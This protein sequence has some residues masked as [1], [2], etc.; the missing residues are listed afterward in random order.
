[1]IAAMSALAAIVLTMSACSSEGARSSESTLAAVWA[2]KFTQALSDPN[3]S[4]FAT[5]VLSD[6]MITQAEYQESFNR[7]CQCLADAG[8]TV[9]GTPG[10]YSV[11]PPDTGPITNQSKAMEEQ[12][13]IIN[14]CQNPDSDSAW[15]TI[16]SI[17]EGLE[18]DPLGLTIEQ[19]IKQCY[20]EHGVPDG[21]GMSDDQFNQMVDDP[22]YVPSTPDAT[23]CLWD[24]TGA[25]GYTIEQAEQ[26][27]A[28]VKS[29]PTI[30][31]SPV[32]TDTG[33]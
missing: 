14:T 24:P 9:S 2:D 30:S 25:M 21:A 13:G 32:P 16:S 26:L 5:Q 28:N 31:S 29:G 23:L 15:I 18:N 6:Y 17:Y 33:T 22:D 8:Y 1:M 3:L 11:T 10:G 7:F 19:L 12:L 4:A 27:Q 20:Q